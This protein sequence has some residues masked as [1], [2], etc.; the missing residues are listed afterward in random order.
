[1]AL[2]LPMCGTWLASHEHFDHAGGLAAL[3]QATGAPLLAS[4]IAAKYLRMGFVSD[5][6]PQRGFGDFQRYPA[7]ANVQGYDDGQTLILGSVQITAHYTPAHSPGSTSWLIKHC[8]GEIC[9]A[10]LYAD[11]LNPVAAP[12]FRF[13]TAKRRVREFNEGLR[14]VRSNKCDVLISP[15]PDQSGLSQRY[16][17]S[18]AGAGLAAF[19]TGK[20]GAASL[21]DV[22]AARLKAALQAEAKAGK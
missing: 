11:S 3:Q 1:M 21:A 18:V 4:N 6:D 19:K 8:N 22:A 12:D 10:T 9:A 17:Q 20:S 5:A 15:H 14:K 13:T 16:E 2:S 7:I